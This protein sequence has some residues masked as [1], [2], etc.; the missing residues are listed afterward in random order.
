M[1][2]KMADYTTSTQKK[3]TVQKEKA[4]TQIKAEKDLLNH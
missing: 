1:E 3:N 2:I 4:R